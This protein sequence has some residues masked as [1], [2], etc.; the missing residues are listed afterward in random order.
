MLSA[1]SIA[2]F[3]RYKGGVGASTL[4]ANTAWLLASAGKRVLAVDADLAAPSLHRLYRPFLTDP[5]L[6][7]TEGLIDA[8]ID[9]ASSAPDDAP[10]LASLVVSVD[11]DFEGSGSLDLLT[12]GR[13]SPLSAY[14]ARV[15]GFRWQ[16]FLEGPDG[17]RFLESA[18]ELRTLY[19][20]ILVDCTSGITE[21]TALCA[22]SIPDTLCLCFTATPQTVEGAREVALRAM[23]ERHQT[24][25]QILPLSMRVDP[26]EKS[27]L[28]DRRRT[29]RAALGPFITH[30]P[31]TEID[32]YWQDTE[33][34][35]VPY[36]GFGEVLPVFFDTPGDVHS[37]CSAS[38]RLCR[39]LAPNETLTFSFPN[40]SQRE[41]TLARYRRTG[42]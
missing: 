27:L 11:W 16:P 10:Q 41:E 28:E 37:L 7:A 9:F 38:E 15:A 35:Y 36:Y 8:A 34:P 42:L 12:A 5:N 32:R 23:Q 39:Y 25:L 26:S 20:F 19:D 29:A 4:L 22:I 17:A 30:V 21:T 40:E 1:G 18:E 13:L 24:P 3:Y 14:A 2:T 33:F 6:T 31:P